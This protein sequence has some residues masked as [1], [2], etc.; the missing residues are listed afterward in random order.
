MA[1]NWD[2]RNGQTVLVATKDVET[3]TPR[4]VLLVCAEPNAYETAPPYE[5]QL[6]PQLRRLR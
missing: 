3:L 5:P 1:V 4:G 6:Y 2:A